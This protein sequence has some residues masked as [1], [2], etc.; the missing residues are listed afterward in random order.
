[1]FLSLNTLVP[2]IREVVRAHPTFNI[3]FTGHSL[4]GAIAVLAAL[5]L[6]SHDPSTGSRI[7]VYTLGSPRIG[8]LGF[9][10]HVQTLPFAHQIFSIRRLGDPIGSTPPRK[11]GYVYTGEQFLLNGDHISRCRV[12]GPGSESSEC[13]SPNFIPRIS[14]H[15]SY[16]GFVHRQQ[17]QNI[18]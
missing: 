6:Y 2:H 3:Y 8:N 5:D 17:C 13:N 16:F 14:R 18:F 11:M 1:M 15:H 10:Q 12:D 4:G 7:S 9:H